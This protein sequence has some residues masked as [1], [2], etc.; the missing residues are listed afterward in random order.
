MGLNPG[1]LI[2]ANGYPG[3]REMYFALHDRGSG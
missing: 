2:N 1:M 3:D